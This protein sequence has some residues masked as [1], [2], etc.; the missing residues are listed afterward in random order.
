MEL[1]VY[2]VVNYALRSRL[3]FRTEAE[4]RQLLGVT[5]ETVRD[6]CDDEDVLQGYYAALN[7]EC[8]SRCGET[9]YY[10]VAS[11]L[12]A[13]RVSQEIDFDWKE[14]RQMASRKKFC[15]WL[16]RK[17][18][19]PGRKISLA[20]ELKF[21]PKACDREL[22]D[23][24]YPQ[25]Y[26]AGRAVDILFI[27]LLTYK[28]IK[29]LEV[30]AA[31]GRDV[32]DRDAEK[33]RQA[34]I[35]LISQLKE[36]MP[37]MGTLPK[38]MI[39]D[40]V[41][42]ELHRTTEPISI[43]DLWEKTDRIENACVA[44]SSPQKA[45]D[46]RMRPNGFSMPGIWVDD[47]DDG[48]TRFWIFPENKYMAFCYERDGQA[49][50][51]SPYE[52]VFFISDSD[53]HSDDYC[54]MVTARGNEQVIESGVMQPSE[55]VSASYKLNGDVIRFRLKSWQAPAWFNW[56]YFC[57][58]QEDDTRN[59]LFRQVIA[60]VYDSNSPHSMLF[61]NLGS[62][63]TDT[64]DA[65]VAMD[66]ECLYI[67]DGPIPKRFALISD[68]GRYYYCPTAAS[69]RSLRSIDIS[70]KHPLYIVPRFLN[71]DAPMSERQ[72][73]VA[74]VAMNTNLSNQVTIYRTASHPDGLLCFNYF[75]TSI[76]LS[77]AS[78]FGLKKVTSRYDFW[79]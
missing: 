19:A 60:D 31:R 65:L 57:R 4:Y 25:G 30:R 6:H 13:S 63:L 54:V 10:M 35:E 18:A 32:S 72:R 37:Q 15:R 70:A 68:D 40:V 52:F 46:V 9:L 73:A 14:R 67:Y 75:S 79:V 22:F 34:M 64:I 7:K 8:Q 5:F 76:P 71:L 29:P 74:E 49:W 26:E 17:V 12:E 48:E 58:L 51:L 47:A 45:A 66:M 21:S 41:L 59:S 33:T 53:D 11:Y 78:T 44:V 36:D 56:H 3:L 69:S 77:E 61:S 23:R 16:F 39:F 42:D 62:L 20:E 27:L 55:A 28:V 43:V 38:P 24:F 50:R 1:S 2:E